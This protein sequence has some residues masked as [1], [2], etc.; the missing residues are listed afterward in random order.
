MVFS[1]NSA[2]C[3]SNKNQD[4]N[5]LLG[6]LQVGRFCIYSFIWVL[7]I[8]GN[9]AVILTICRTK[10]LRS[11]SNYLIVNLAV[12]DLASLCIA[13][14]MILIV[15]IT[16]W[17][18][19]LIVCRF[20]NPLKDLFLHVS[21]ITITVIAIDRYVHTVY[22][23][24]TPIPLYKVKLII[25]LIWLVDYLLIPL[26]MGF[27]M[28]IQRHQMNGHE[29][30]MAIFT[31]EW[32][33]ISIL[34]LSSFLF[35]SLFLTAFAYVGVGFVMFKQRKRIKLRAQDAGI[36]ARSLKR[37]LEKNLKTV[38]LMMAIVVAFWLSVLPLTMFALLLELK[39]LMPTREQYV[40][41]FFLASHLLFLQH[42]INPVILYLLSKDMRAGF[43]KCCTCFSVFRRAN[44]KV[45]NPQQRLLGNGS[46]TNE[47]LK[48]Y[49]LHDEAK[50]T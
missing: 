41:I 35:L 38:K 7:G 19:G 9:I 42:C 13:M 47:M 33:K 32:Q 12:A 20:I 22:P 28:K 25:L 40:I 27:V 39:V 11:S 10:R 46:G 31:P 43:Y 21:M 29:V 49:S 17:P 34:L 14:P 44:A 2:T 24:K 30:C 6:D 23:F 8:L 5:K 3:P 48:M 18:F 4:F 15:Q 36:H 37:E 26:P 50:C 1:N 45:K 16:D